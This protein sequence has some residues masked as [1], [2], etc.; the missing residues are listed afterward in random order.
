MIRKTE[1]TA[2]QDTGLYPMFRAAVRAVS[3]IGY[4]VMCKGR[5]SLSLRAMPLRRRG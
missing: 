4:L 1:L 5:F 2:A 3:R